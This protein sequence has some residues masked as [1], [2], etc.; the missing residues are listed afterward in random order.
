M[1]LHCLGGACFC[2]HTEAPLSCWQRGQTIRWS[3][4]PTQKREISVLDIELR[5]AVTVRFREN[6][7]ST[8]HRTSSTYHLGNDDSWP[9]WPV[10]HHYYVT[11]FLGGQ[12]GYENNMA[13][14][15]GQVW[16]IVIYSQWVDKPS[17]NNRAGVFLEHSP[18]YLRKHC[19]CRL[20][21]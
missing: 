14:C 20:V 7:V 21:V 11:P 5:N 3:L 8:A 16:F 6:G 4:C 17:F 9:V 13:G 19:C 2:W 15:K 1:L 10:T 12:R 18:S